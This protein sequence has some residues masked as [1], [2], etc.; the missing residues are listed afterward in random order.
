MRDLVLMAILYGAVPFILFRPVVGIWF[1]VL[2]SVMAPHR[3]GWGSAFDQPF[4]LV[5]AMATVMGMLFSKEPKRLPMTPFTLIVLLMVVWLVITT[6]FAFDT[7]GSMP[8]LERF[9]KLQ[10]MLFVTM[11]LLHTRQHVHTLIWILTASVA[12]Y[13]VKGGLFTLM[14]G[15]I[16]RVFGPTGSY[17]EENNTLAL[18]LIMA[19]PLL[20]YLH[21]QSTN[22][23]LRWGLVAS[24]VLC[25]FSVLGSQSRGAFIAGAAMLAMF[26]LKGKNKLSV[27]LLLLVLVPLAIGFMPDQYGKR[28]ETIETYD[29]DASAQGRINAWM[30]AWNL[31]KDRPLVGGGFDIY[32]YSIF[33][34]YAPDPTDVHAAHS[35]Y[36]TMLGEHGFVGLA[37]FLLLWFVVWRDASWIIRKVKD[38][39][40]LKWASDLASMVQVS[41]AGYAVGGAFL[42]LA[43]FDVPYNLAVA[44]VLTRILIAKEIAR[45]SPSRGP[46]GEWTS[47]RRLDPAA[48]MR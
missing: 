37:L 2:V 16:D 33:A 9:L 19:I 3:L 48:G 46:R 21:L 8:F 28:M 39:E 23:K 20:R 15:G 40:E 7:L 12:F 6:A 4:G 38:R 17:I 34:R 41:L 11:Y 10:F 47:T 26:W 5:F 30:M 25:G 24:M 18:A 43:Y 22:P 29:R 27:G 35:I 44:L 32:N 1:W 45:E 14:G 31:A 42:S 36:F 13:G